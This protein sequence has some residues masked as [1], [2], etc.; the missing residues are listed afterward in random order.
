LT[1]Q[2]KAQ[3]S[4]DITFDTLQLSGN[5]TF[6]FNLSSPGN[7]VGFD[8]GNLYF[9]SYYDT[10]GGFAYWNGGWSF[11]NVSDTST[12]GYLNDH[13]VISGSGYGGSG[14]Y[15]VFFQG[16]ADAPITVSQVPLDT[17]LGPVPFMGVAVMS[18]YVNNSTYAYLSMRDGDGFAKKFGGAT[19]DDPDFF[20]LTIYGIDTN[21]VVFD[22]AEHYLADFRNPDNTQDFIQKDWQN[23]YLPFYERTNKIE[24]VLSSSDTGAF[25]MNTPAYVCIDN[26]E[27]RDIYESGIRNV[28]TIKASC[29][30]NPATETVTVKCDELVKV[31]VLDMA[32]RQVF[33]DLTLSAEH[34]IIMSE[35]P[36]GNYQ[37]YISNRS[38]SA[39]IQIAKNR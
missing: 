19:G 37:M 17:A 38:G 11:S 9:P 5:D 20:K 39:T 16:F 1:T 4:Q 12:P 2:A 33:E 29:Y 24:F 18:I 13:A 30:P 8:D 10:S 22:S 26:I 31:R 36:V 3:I 6:Y 32:G 15:G 28:P 21:G 25:G 27:L 23:V 34:K 14:N 35:L 7:D